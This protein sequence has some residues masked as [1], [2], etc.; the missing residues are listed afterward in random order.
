MAANG[1][2]ETFVE[3]I[4]RAST[5]LPADVVNAL[6]QGKAREEES[7]LAGKALGTILDNVELARDTSAPICQDT[8]TPVVWF[9]PVSYTHLTLPTTLPRCRSRWSPYQ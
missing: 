6:E 3:L 2:V 7:G 5:Q 4:R 8:G 1:N 9:H